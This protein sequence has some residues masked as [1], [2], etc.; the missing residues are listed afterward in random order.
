MSLK[1]NK[2]GAAPLPDEKKA[3][4]PGG[5]PDPPRSS[6]YRAVQ[7]FPQ[8]TTPDRTPVK[9]L[10]G[11]EKVHVKAG[12]RQIHKFE[13]TRKDMSFKNVVK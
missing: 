5:Y 2:K 13:I 6:R 3:I 8:D 11:F 12:H 10:R 9:M 1:S 4:E 7:A